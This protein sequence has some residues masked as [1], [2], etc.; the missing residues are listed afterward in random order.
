MPREN[1]YGAFHYRLSADGDLASV[2]DQI[3]FMEV[4]G[5]DTETMPMEYRDSR[6]PSD[7]SEQYVRKLPGMESYPNVVLRRGITGHTDLWVW[8]QRVRDGEPWEDVRTNITVTLTDE[9]NSGAIMRWRLHDAW[10]CKLSGPVL[11]ARTNEIAIE[12][13]ELCCDRIELL[14]A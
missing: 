7:T 10:P 11:N 9:R 4:S 12:T 1:P 8:R 13:L 3:G 2:F 5:L 14:V 6:V